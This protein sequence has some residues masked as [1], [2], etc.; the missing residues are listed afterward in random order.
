MWVTGS[1]PG[2]AEMFIPAALMKLYLYTSELY[3]EEYFRSSMSS[4]VILTLTSWLWTATGWQQR[5]W[6]APTS[7]TFLL[8][9]SNNLFK[10]KH[11]ERTYCTFSWQQLIPKLF[12]NICHW[13]QLNMQIVNHDWYISGKQT[14]VQTMKWLIFM[15]Y[16]IYCIFRGL[17]KKVGEYQKLTGELPGLI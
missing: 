15:I 7:R 17:K 5:S 13:L 9:S 14:P 6:P 8:S 12:S 3:K 2:E 1:H 11:N 10:K 4:C 16:T